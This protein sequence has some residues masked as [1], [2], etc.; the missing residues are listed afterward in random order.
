MLGK[1]CEHEFCYQCSAPYDGDQG[2]YEIGNSAHDADCRHYR[3]LNCDSD[4]ENEERYLQ[5]DE[6]IEDDAEYATDA[7]LIE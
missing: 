3:P 2:I 4:D 7:V 1:K 6:Y 5:H